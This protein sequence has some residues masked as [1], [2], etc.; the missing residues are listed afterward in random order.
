MGVSGLGRIA[1]CAGV[2]GALLTGCTPKQEA[3][4]TAQSGN[5]AQAA[6]PAPSPLKPI[7][8]VQ[9]IMAG[10]I[11]TRRCDVVRSSR[12]LSTNRERQINFGTPALASGKFRH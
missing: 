5:A 1:A 12:H 11:D 9:D 8:G 10:M 4:V 3:A 6:A 2:L 7:A